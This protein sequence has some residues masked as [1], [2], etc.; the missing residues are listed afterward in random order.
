MTMEAIIEQI[1]DLA[2][3]IGSYWDK[4][5]PTMPGYPNVSSLE[6]IQY[7]PKEKGELLD[8]LV[9][10]SRE[11]FEFVL[12]LNNFEGRYLRL[13]QFPKELE[14]VRSRPMN[15]RVVASGLVALGRILSFNLRQAQKRLEKYGVSVRQLRVENQATSLSAV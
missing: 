1:I 15:R 4:K 12:A 14:A 7:D 5:L 10:L 2:E 3:R 13:D 6:M 8:F 11:D 9:G